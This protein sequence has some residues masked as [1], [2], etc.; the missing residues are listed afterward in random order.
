[1]RFG[2]GGMGSA[3]PTARQALEDLWDLWDARTWTVPRVSCF[4]VSRIRRVVLS[5]LTRRSLSLALVSARCLSV[6]RRPYKRRRRSARA[7]KNN[8]P[9]EQWP[10]RVFPLAE[11]P[12]GSGS[13]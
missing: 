9:L 10:E 1:M 8:R 2:V 5:F 4:T 12:S 3:K 11:L 13:K 6:P 7:S